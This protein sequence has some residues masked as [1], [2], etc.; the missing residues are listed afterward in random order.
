M[1]TKS[2]KHDLTDLSQMGRLLGTATTP[3]AELAPRKWDCKHASP[4][5]AAATPPHGPSGKTS[6]EPSPEP[7]DGITVHCL[8]RFPESLLETAVARAR[9]TDSAKSR[10]LSQ[11]S[12]LGPGSGVAVH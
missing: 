9:R 8:R 6:N 4:K 3:T 2:R 5:N 1:R 7:I 11:R 10:A 12:R